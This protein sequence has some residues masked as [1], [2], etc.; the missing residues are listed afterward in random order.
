MKYGAKGFLKNVGFLLDKSPAQ[1]DR[2]MMKLLD[3][4]QK[5]RFSEIWYFRELGISSGLE[6]YTVPTTVRQAAALWSHDWPRFEA[7]FEWL[8]G[9]MDA[10]KPSSVLEVGAGPGFLLAFLQTLFPA[11]KYSGIESC[12]N[13]VRIAEGLVGAP[14][15]PGDYLKLKPADTFEMVICNFGFDNDAFAPSIRE[16]GSARIGKGDYCPNCSDDMLHQC[17]P[18]I[19]AW[20]KWAMPDGTLAL[21]GRIRNFGELRAWI[22]AASAYKFGIDRGLTKIITVSSLD[23][24]RERFPA[25]FFKA[26]DNVTA[27]E[28]L[29]WISQIYI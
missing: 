12:D 8:A 28:D 5:E 20:K 14:I 7:G 24:T 1:I 3:E 25:I 19:E 16:H 4:K 9:L 2:A 22:L 21:V 10:L 11:T 17:K 6:Q 27:L 15:I 26:S 13:F 18:Y 23:G 29:D